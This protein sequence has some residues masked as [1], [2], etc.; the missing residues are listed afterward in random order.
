MAEQIY[1]NLSLHLAKESLAC[2]NH[3][4]ALIWNLHRLTFRM[5]WWYSVTQASTIQQAVSWQCL[6][7]V[8]YRPWM[9]NHNLQSFLGFWEHPAWHK[10]CETICKA[11]WRPECKR[12]SKDF[13][14]PPWLQIDQSPE[15]LSSSDPCEQHLWS[16]WTPRQMLL[17]WP[18]QFSVTK[19]DRV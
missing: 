17:A 6:I 10:Q 15:C 8:V 16:A 11:S 18:F 5:W 3:V 1:R 7:N 2:S 4:Q 19:A 9:M 12:A 13:I 14:Y